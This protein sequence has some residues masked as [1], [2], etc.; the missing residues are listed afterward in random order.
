VQRAGR[1]AVLAGE[2]QLEQR[3]VTRREVDV[4]RRRRLHPRV[5]GL[6]RAGDGRPQL[7]AELVEPGL[8][9]RVE[10]RLAI[11]EMAPRGAVADADLACELAQRQRLDPVL[12]DGAVRLLQQRGAQVAV[13]VG[14]RAHGRSVANRSCH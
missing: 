14:P 8:G 13:V 5:E 11:R 7:G 9:E 12:A 4:G 6:A 3:R 1:L 10:Q 2:H